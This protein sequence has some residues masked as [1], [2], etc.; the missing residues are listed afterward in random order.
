MMCV[1]FNEIARFVYKR[2]FLQISH[3]YFTDI[4][5]NFHVRKYYNI[6]VSSVY[7]MS[8][9]LVLMIPIDSPAGAPAT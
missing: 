1:V 3:R 4:P 5:A 7:Y 2:H 8:I 9:L 6:C